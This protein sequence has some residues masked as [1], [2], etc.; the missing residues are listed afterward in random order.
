MQTLQLPACALQCFL[1]FLGSI[2]WEHNSYLAH[3]SGGVP[4][5]WRLCCQCSLTA[6]PLLLAAVLI[7]LYGTRPQSSN[8]LEFASAYLQR[9]ELLR[10][11]RLPDDRERHMPFFRV[12]EAVPSSLRDARYSIPYVRSHHPRRPLL[13][14]G[15]SAG[16]GGYG[17]VG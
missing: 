14:L 11:H 8:I 17:G 3:A 5:P 16:H 4:R 7:Y 9:Q 6:I 2:K 1:I 13:Y 12:R 15:Y 10:A